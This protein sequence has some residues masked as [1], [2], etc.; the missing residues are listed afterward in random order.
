MAFLSVEEI[1]DLKRKV[2]IVDLLSQYMALNK[3]GRNYLGL[4]PFHGEKT[5]S[6]NV[7]AEKGFYHCFG[8]GKSGDILDFLQ[9]Y[10]Q[11]DFKQALTELG[12]FAGVSVKFDGDNQQKAENP[13]AVLY[14]INNQAANL[15][16]VALMNSPEA[17]NYLANRGIDVELIKRYNL[18]LALD[19]EDFIYQNLSVKFDEETLAKSGLFNF[20]T[21]KVYD[22]FQ[23][24]IMFPIRNEY[25]QTIGFSGRIWQENDTQKGKY[26]NT[27]ATAIFDKSY[28]LYNFDLA[29]SN[30][31]KSKEVYLMEGPADV[32]AAYQAGIVNAVATMGTALTEKHVKRLMRLAQ[33]FVLVYDGDNAGQNAINK[34]ISLIGQDKVQIVRVPE[35]L[36]PDEYSKRYSF[37]SLSNLMKNGRIQPLEFVMDYERPEH[38]SNLQAQLDFLEKM[39]PKIADE[40]SITAQDA[41]VRKL[42]EI[43]PEFDYNQVENAVNLEREK[44]RSSSNLT[45]TI[46]E[47]LPP[48]PDYP[49]DYGYENLVAPVQQQFT[50]VQQV[51]K[52]KNRIENA[53]EILLNR[54][55]FHENVIAR[56]AQDTNFQ[57]V[58]GEYQAL[59]DKI[60][61][62]YLTYDVVNIDR[63]TLNLTAD[64]KSVFYQILDRNLPEDLS[65][66]E[67]SDLMETLSNANHFERLT[68]IENE[69]D[70]AKKSGNMEKMLEL[71]IQ[72]VNAKKKLTVM[73]DNEGKND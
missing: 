66:D 55:I 3:S 11:I 46:Y 19:A 67:L 26:I 50:A 58:H 1:S 29:K 28:E 72:Y 60:L 42:V 61:L 52:P 12:E 27:S 22:T 35:N 41:Y 6:F 32:F 70:L 14:E 45:E 20:L 21:N 53:E 7:N 71:T 2:N 25:G 44:R 31:N 33:K 9:E 5:P 15:Y 51:F 40:P 48:A 18:G 36:D 73:K 68:E 54:M 16:N 57:F 64:E 56:L 24:R 62:D 10:K 38:L 47:D 69:L 13:N 39:A 8:C 63:L 43:L 34:A 17:L 30:I 49:D 37:E 23:N 4:C 59:F 65:N